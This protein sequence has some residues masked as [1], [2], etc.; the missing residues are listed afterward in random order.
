V[1]PLM[2]LLTNC[3]HTEAKM[4]MFISDCVS[5]HVHLPHCL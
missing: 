1:A 5:V 3:M 2:W 4:T